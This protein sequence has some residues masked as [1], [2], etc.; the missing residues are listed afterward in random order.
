MFDSY[1]WKHLLIGVSTAVL[2]RLFGF[3]L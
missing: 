2:V 3:L 1:Y